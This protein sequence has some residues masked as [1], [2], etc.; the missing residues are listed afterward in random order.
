MKYIGEGVLNGDHF[1]TIPKG[2]KVNVFDLEI[3]D[4]EF[5]RG[6]EDIYIV[7]PNPPYGRN[8]GT[9]AF[10]HEVDMIVDRSETYQVISEI[11]NQK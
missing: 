8:Y 11:R 9:E 6:D 3:S 1:T 10:A 7:W 2:I 4:E 5:N